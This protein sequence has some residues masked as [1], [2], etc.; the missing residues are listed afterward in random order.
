MKWVL[1]IPDGLPDG[2]AAA[3][4]GILAS[5][6]VF[7]LAHLKLGTRLSLGFGLVLALLF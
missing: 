1:S 4:A 5:R 2:T 7:M 6:R 3:S